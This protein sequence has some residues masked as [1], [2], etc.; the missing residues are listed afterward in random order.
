MV[1]SKQALHV[2]ALGDVR[3]DGDGVAAGLDDFAHHPIGVGFARSVIHRNDRPRLGEGACDRRADPLR[4]PSDDRDL[5]GQLAHDCLLCSGPP[6]PAD[7]RF[8]T[9]D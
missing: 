5:P 1:S 2:G 8:L 7:R 4:S 3:L 6:R 9:V